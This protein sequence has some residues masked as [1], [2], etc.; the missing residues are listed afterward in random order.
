MHPMYHLRAISSVCYAFYFADIAKKVYGMEMIFL[1]YFGMLTIEFF[2]NLLEINT[3]DIKTAKILFHYRFVNLVT[4]IFHLSG[5][6]SNS[7]AVF[8][9]TISLPS[10]WLFVNLYYKN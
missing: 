4:S 3:L 10:S 9:M 8:F 6:Y 5:I 7:C 2:V 1:S